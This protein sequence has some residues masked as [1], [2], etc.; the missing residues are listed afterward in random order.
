MI[1]SYKPS[2]LNENQINHLKNVNPFWD[3]ELKKAFK[4]LEKWLL[5]FN[6][7]L[8]NFKLTFTTSYEQYSQMFKSVDNYKNFFNQKYSL[9]KSNVRILKKFHKF[10]IDY[11]TT[12]GIVKAIETIANYF[13]GINKTDI[14]NK[15]QY[16]LELI[17]KIIDQNLEIFKKE[18][19]VQ[20]KNDEYIPMVVDQVIKIDTKITD[21][22]FLAII[23]TKYLRQ[24][25]KVKKISEDKFINCNVSVIE[26]YAYINSFS[27]IM[28]HFLKDVY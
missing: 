18:L 10:I 21:I 15:K 11:C 16:C 14:G 20:L 24:L 1:N 4:K 13:E 7:N 2:V 26:F 5:K 23:V 19:L 25:L 12:L 22:S 9:I 17:N 3:K 28:S 27:F 6:K 8:D